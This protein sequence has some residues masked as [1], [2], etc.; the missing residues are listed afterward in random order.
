MADLI[1]FSPYLGW[2]DVTNSKDIPENARVISASDLLR[3]EKLGQD[4]A[5]RL[6]DP[7]AIASAVLPEI[8]SQLG[9]AFGRRLDLVS[10]LVKPIHVAH[11]GGPL[12]YPEHSMESYRASAQAGFLPEQDIH[13]LADGTLVC[14]HD[15]TTGRT[16]TG[17]SVAVN[18]LTREQWLARRIKP[19]ITGGKQAMPVLW[20]DVLNEFGGRVVLMPEI[21]GTD[22]VVARK[23]IDSILERGL[24]RCVIV[25]SFDR[26]ANLM[27]A[28]AGIATLALAAGSDPTVLATLQANNVEFT[29]PGVTVTAALMATYRSYGMR[30]IPYTST[31]YATTESLLALGAE[32]VFMDDPWGSSGQFLTQNWQDFTDGTRWAGSQGVSGNDSIGPLPNGKLGLLMKGLGGTRIIEQGW[33]GE[34][35]NRNM[36]VEFDLWRKDAKVNHDSARVYLSRDLHKA[37]GE[38]VGDWILIVVRASGQLDVFRR[39]I[40]DTGGS[41]LVGSQSK[42]LPSVTNSTA[43]DLH[44]IRIGIDALGAIHI[45]KLSDGTGFTVPPSASQPTDGSWWLSVG[46]LGLSAGYGSF[47]VDHAATAGPPKPPPSNTDPYAAKS[48]WY[49]A[50]GFDSAKDSFV[51]MGNGKTGFKMAN[52]T[53][54]H[55]MVEQGWAGEIPARGASI[56]FDI[57]RA[58]TVDN[59]SSRIYLSTTMNINASESQDTWLLLALRGNG[60]VVIFTKV[61][62]GATIAAGEMWDFLPVLTGAQSDT[63]RVKLTLA[64]DGSITVTNSTNS[65]TLTVAAAKAGLPT[66]PLWMSTASLLIDSTFA[67]FV[68]TR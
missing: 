38:G 26:P 48:V 10:K 65:K 57:R 54:A 15:D 31:N 22:L 3:Y 58:N 62:G 63:H 37:A 61:A 29:G 28:Q 18:T 64:A 16:M 47:I 46:N 6:N 56:E 8:K 2:V 50:A 33:A 19:A 45:M 35:P 49:G 42:F 59:G 68:I 12:R 39:T 17:P 53:Q 66:A 27:S 52:T 43:G 4:V 7:I 36:T 9:A 1:K 67:G 32:G 21:K 60:Q 51:D 34:L 13:M 24:E 20:E 30:S 11:R 5:A 55:H 23:V 25:Q 14:V 41:V 44:R 40:G